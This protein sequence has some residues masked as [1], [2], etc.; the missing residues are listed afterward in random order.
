M[1][2]ETAEASEGRNVELQQ[3]LDDD[4]YREPIDLTGRKTSADGH[5][6]VSTIVEQAAFP[7][8]ALS[9]AK[10]ASCVN[11]VQNRMLVL[12]I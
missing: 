4:F 8:R 7:C 11:V 5:A 9:G 1:T 12:F 10:A 3:N 2:A 6:K